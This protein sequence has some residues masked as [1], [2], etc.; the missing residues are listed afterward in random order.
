M[1]GADCCLIMQVLVALN[2]ERG[3]HR[4]AP[5]ALLLMPPC[6]TQNWAMRNAYREFY[7]LRQELLCCSSMMRW[8]RLSRQHFESFT[9]PTPQDRNSPSKL[10]QH[11]DQCKTRIKAKEAP[12]KCAHTSV[13]F[14]GRRKVNSTV[15]INFRSKI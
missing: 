13:L 11:D 15:S 9:L 7:L 8:Y 1:S 12:C 14:F 6:I 2:L 3:E 4:S 10:Q 5:K